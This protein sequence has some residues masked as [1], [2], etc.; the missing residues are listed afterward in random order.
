VRGLQVKLLLAYSAATA[1]ETPF[2]AAP[3]QEISKKK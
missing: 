1:A 2:D 3:C